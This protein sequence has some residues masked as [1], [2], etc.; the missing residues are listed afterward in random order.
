MISVPRPDNDATVMIATPKPE[1]DATVM[2]PAAAAEPDAEATIA[3]PTPGR[4][5]D[6][7]PAALPAAPLAG[8]VAVPVEIGEL[9]GVN[10]L[11]AAANPL[12]AAVAQ[13]RHT[14]THADPE[15]L[16]A[17]LRQRIEAFEATARAAGAGDEH[18][19]AARFALDAW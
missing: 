4:R 1:D 13:I 8:R 2:M 6:A 12:L 3:I 17:S 19:A 14:L 5:R 18:L 7:E 16:R 10:P 9:G 11:V 15:G